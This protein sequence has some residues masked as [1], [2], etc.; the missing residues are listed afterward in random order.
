MSKCIIYYNYLIK[1]DFNHLITQDN[2]C[3]QIQQSIE[4]NV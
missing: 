1:N 4:E 3:D 2:N